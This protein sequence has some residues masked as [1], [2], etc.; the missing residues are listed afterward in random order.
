MRPAACAAEMCVSRSGLGFATMN[1]VSR[2][3]VLRQSRARATPLALSRVHRLTRMSSS[4]KD[5][6]S[7]SCKYTK[8]GHHGVPEASFADGTAR[9]N[10]E[11]GAHRKQQQDAW[12]TKPAPV[13]QP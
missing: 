4:E 1:I 5:V 9:Q 8:Q 3:D 11:V 12:A 6:Q 10:H 13:Q 7:R 2:V